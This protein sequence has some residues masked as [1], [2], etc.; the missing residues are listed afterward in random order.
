MANKGHHDNTHNHR[1]DGGAHKDAPA[2]IW[3]V[4]HLVEHLR[5]YLCE[6]TAIVCV[7]NELCGDDG[8]G[9][10]V[11]RELAGKVSWKIF[12][13]QTVPESFLMKI[14]K[15]E[16]ET[17]ILIDALHLG[18][19]PGA[20]ELIEPGELTGQGPSTHGPAPLAFLDILKMFHPSSRRVVLGIQPA[21][22]D[23]GTEMCPEV[24][25]AVTRIVQAFQL[26]AQDR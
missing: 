26:I 7:G 22:T 3:T 20:V 8:A 19:S 18:S 24:R 13:T 6:T 5:E 12:E 10:A 1:T 25:N 4:E 2:G 23:F 9:V 17:V 11:A 14:V 21:N 15:G 16:P